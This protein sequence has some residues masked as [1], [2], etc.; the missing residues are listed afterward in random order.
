MHSKFHHSFNIS[1]ARSQAGR[2]ICFVVMFPTIA[3]VGGG[4]GSSPYG[5]SSPMVRRAVKSPEHATPG[6]FALFGIA[7]FGVG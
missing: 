2:R 3:F 4:T 1:A 7:D 6:W 5:F